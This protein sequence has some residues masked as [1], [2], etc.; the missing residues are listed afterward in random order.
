MCIF[1]DSTSIISV[2]NF[3][4]YIPLSLMFKYTAIQRKFIKGL[5]MFVDGLLQR[6]VLK[7][8]EFGFAWL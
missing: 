7:Y 5:Y 4:H 1:N 8:I 6:W 3:F 2:L